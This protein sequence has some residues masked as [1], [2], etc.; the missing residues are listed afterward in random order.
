[1]GRLTG[2]IHS[3][4]EDIIIDI[5]VQ[6]RQTDCSGTVRT[7]LNILD[8]HIVVHCKQLLHLGIVTAAVVAVRI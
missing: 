2:S 5:G 7:G 3:H 4:N 8:V 6:C 1:M